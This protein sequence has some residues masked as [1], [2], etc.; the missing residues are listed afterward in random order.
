MKQNEISL[1]FRNQ[2]ISEFIYRASCTNWKKFYWVHYKVFFFLLIEKTNKSKGI[3]FDLT[4]Q[5]N[6]ESINKFHQIFSWKI[7][8]KNKFNL[9]LSFHTKLEPFFLVL[10]LLNDSKEPLSPGKLLGN[11]ESLFCSLFFNP[12]KKTLWDQGY[13]KVTTIESFLWIFNQ[14]LI[15]NREKG[16][17]GPRALLIMM[18]SF[19]LIVIS[20]TS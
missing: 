10:S 5:F 12:T 15:A 6:N 17:L 1:S 9:V 18:K 11:E 3:E 8:K 13:L 14:I 4:K 16:K 19:L 20:D 2:Q 7:R